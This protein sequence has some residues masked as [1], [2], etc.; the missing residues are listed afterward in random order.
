MLTTAGKSHARSLVCACAC[1]CA[2]WQ[3]LCESEGIPPQAIVAQLADKMWST[4]LGGM[5]A[6]AEAVGGLP[7][8]RRTPLIAELVLSHVDKGARSHRICTAS[9]RSAP[10]AF[11]PHMH[12]EQALSAAPWP[13]ENAFALTWS[14]LYRPALAAWRS[15]AL[16]LAPCHMRAIHSP[17]EREE[18][19]GGRAGHGGR[20]G[21]LL[22]V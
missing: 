4:R 7:A 20:Q 10:W 19:A 6:L 17:R 11:A 12:R 22:V 5:Q 14:L 8:E 9:K 15:R 2:W 18:P 3:A 21:R 1:V 13:R 16:A